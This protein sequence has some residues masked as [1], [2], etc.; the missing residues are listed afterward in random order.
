MSKRRMKPFKDGIYRV[1]VDRGA[2]AEVVL[3]VAI[4]FF[5]RA[6]GVSTEFLESLGF[7][8]GEIQVEVLRILLRRTEEAY[9]LAAEVEAE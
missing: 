4:E 6:L 7:E 9:G 8:S 3:N 5:L 1:S 2:P